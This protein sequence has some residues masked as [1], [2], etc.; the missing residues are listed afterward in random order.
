MWFGRMF[1]FMIGFRFGVCLRAD[2]VYPR[3]FVPFFAVFV[4][5][6]R[7]KRKRCVSVPQYFNA[8]IYAPMDQFFH[9]QP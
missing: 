2:R 9:I 4:Q 8:Y 1:I 7:C 6:R 3:D 5:L